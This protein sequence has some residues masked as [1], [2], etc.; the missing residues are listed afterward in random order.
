M[1]S[2]WIFA[3]SLIDNPFLVHPF[4]FDV[5]EAAPEIEPII[6]PHLNSLLPS[7]AADFNDSLTSPVSI[8]AI[9]PEAAPPITPDDNAHT[10]PDLAATAKTELTAAAPT[11]PDTADT[12]TQINMTPVP[13]ATFLI[14]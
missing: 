5:C 9:V 3:A 14:I 6:A 7:K 1:E 10:V 11:P 4:S 8:Y 2:F 12:V 13:T